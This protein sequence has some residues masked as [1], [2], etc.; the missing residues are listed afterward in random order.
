MNQVPQFHVGGIAIDWL[1]CMHVIA[2][3]PARRCSKNRNRICVLLPFYFLHFPI[4]VFTGWLGGRVC[5]GTHTDDGLFCVG[6]GV[7]V[8][9]ECV[10]YPGYDVL[11]Y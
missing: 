6:I 8:P 5:L 3:R 4:L 10:V 9:V 1:E 2:R 11:L 7:G